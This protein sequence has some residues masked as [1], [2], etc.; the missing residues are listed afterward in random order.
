MTTMPDAMPDAMR[1]ACDP[2]MH[3]RD[4]RTDRTNERGS[5]PPV[6]ISPVRYA[7]DAG[8][9]EISGCEA[10][11]HGTKHAYYAYGCRCAAAR[12]AC[13]A[14][15][16]ARHKDAILGKPRAVDATGTTRRVRALMALGWPQTEVA[17]VAGIGSR[18]LSYI[19]RGCSKWCQRRTADAIR[20][21]YDQ[22]SMTPGPSPH[23]RGR[24]LKAGWLPPLAWDED[25]IDDPA[26]RP[27]VECGS[28]V[29]E[30]AVRRFLAGDGTVTLTWDE[31]VEA[32][33]LS[34]SHGWSTSQL[35]VALGLSGTAMAK[36]RGA[37]QRP[38]AAS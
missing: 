13:A 10:D 37:A 8:E 5:N 6:D 21:A 32:V 25:A 18:H 1:S 20:R 15:Q 7:R 35:K 33:R 12:A 19:A 22:L 24:A 11:R 29:D 3:V 4:V 36:A 14:Y 17:K 28:A 23:I 26:A 2:H 9:S 27:A 16:A 30:I 34:E 31:K 38:L